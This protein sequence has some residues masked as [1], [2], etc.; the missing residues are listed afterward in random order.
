MKKTGAVILL[1]LLFLS[2]LSDTLSTNA[3]PAP[4]T[5]IIK[6]KNMKSIGRPCTYS[7]L[8]GYWSMVTVDIFAPSM[9]ADDLSLT[10]YQI[11]YFSKSRHVFNAR[12]RHPV[13]PKDYPKIKK[14]LTKANLARTPFV[15]KNDVEPGLL[16]FI[17]LNHNPPTYG[18]HL[19]YLIE[20]E[21]SPLKKGELYLIK[22]GFNGK[23]IN[24]ATGQSVDAYAPLFAY[25]LKRTKL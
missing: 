22:I 6:M 5:P 11:W 15:L 12:L 21:I 25:H 4:K 3:K 13:T 24:P 20:K 18:D 10:H 2:L 9:P 1:S 19:C 8:H 7:D 23:K 14:G 17:H 16:E